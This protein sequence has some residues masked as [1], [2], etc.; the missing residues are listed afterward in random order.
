MAD[1]EAKTRPPRVVIFGAGITGLTVAHELIERG[2]DVQVVESKA[3]EESEYEVEVGGVAANQFAT[4]KADLEE[5]HPH[6]FKT[7]RGAYIDE[8]RRGVV[9]DQDVERGIPEAEKPGERE[10]LEALRAYPMQRSQ[11][12]ARLSQVFTFD[13]CSDGVA[14]FEDPEQE[15]T[16][17]RAGAGDQEF[18]AMRNS[19]LAL[20]DAHGITNEEKLTALAKRI[21]IAIVLR[22]ER[23]ATDIEAAER[24]GS[25]QIAGKLHDISVRREILVAEFWG[26]V[27]PDLVGEST[28]ELGLLRSRFVIWLLTEQA[29]AAQ[30][31]AEVGADG[32][33]LD[34]FLRQKSVYES[35]TDGAPEHGNRER[36][37]KA[38]A[39]IYRGAD[40]APEVDEFIRNATHQ[41]IA[42][43]AGAARPLGT[44]LQERWRSN[45]V[46]VRVVE[47]RLPGEHGYR[48][49]P[50]Y[51]RHLFN[52]MR[53]TP[54]LDATG[55]EGLETAFDQLVQPPPVAIAL[56][57]SGKSHR[58]PRRHKGIEDLRK[59]LA[60]LLDDLK[61]TQTDLQRFSFRLLVFLTSCRERRID[62][63]EQSWLE[64]LDG[65]KGHSA[66]YAMRNFSDQGQ[67][68]VRG[69]LR[70]LLAMDGEEI[71]AH[72]YALN[73]AQL[74]LD[75]R[76]EHAGADM[77]LIGPSSTTW[78][79]P[80]KR[81]LVTQ[82]VEF[83]SGELVGL[84][85][86]GDGLQPVVLWGDHPKLTPGVPIDRPIER[87][88][89]RDKLLGLGANDADGNL[90]IAAEYAPKPE[91]PDHEY[92][93]WLPHGGED[94]EQPDY[95][96]LALPFERAA[97][98][99]WRAHRTYTLD[100]DWKRLAEF[101]E[102]TIERDD[103]GFDKVQHS[104]EDPIHG[105]RRDESGR[106][107]GVEYPLR[108]LSGIQFFF[109]NN[110]RLVDGHVIYPHSAWGLSAISQMGHWRDRRSRRE[111]FLG[112]F[113]VDI[114]DFYRVHRARTNLGYL[115][116]VDARIRSGLGDPRTA[117]RS[118]W[119]E[120]AAR[121]W[122][123][124][125]QT[126]EPEHAKVLVPPR[127][128]HLDQGIYFESP[129]A[130]ASDGGGTTNDTNRMPAGNDTPFLINLPGQF[131]RRP[132]QIRGAAQNRHGA[133]R[134]MTVRPQVSNERWV[135]AGTYMAT[136]TR[137]MTMEAS[138][139]SGRH[140]VN[141][142]LHDIMK[143]E[144]RLLGSLCEIF[145]P[146]E[147]EVEDFAPLKELDKAL[148][149]EG[150]PHL[151]EILGFERL[152]QL[153]HRREGTVGGLDA[154]RQ[155]VERDWGFAGRELMRFLTPPSVRD[156]VD[157]LHGVLPDDA[158]LQ[159]LLAAARGS[160]VEASL[161]SLIDLF[162]YLD[163]WGVRRP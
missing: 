97:Q 106:P 65:A 96:L 127:Y 100:G 163:R 35:G 116:K 15:L 52:T 160:P 136:Y 102:L 28:R 112:Q 86:D 125:L 133:A 82:G 157:P 40:R 57:E 153:A 139:E 39:R 113:S 132:G 138:N 135:L 68:L 123:Q 24:Y 151:L 46:E 134:P 92:F 70:S 162:A 88:Q 154:L 95:Y 140:A 156:L 11:P 146:Y 141:T 58:I 31:A 120:L 67:Q 130:G 77:T 75:V 149:D 33:S 159:R 114:G 87:R 4:V 150:L 60:F 17:L 23:L 147:F 109:A 19:F 99:A 110:T 158:V 20:K 129:S 74:L 56:E 124:L 43:S 108:D 71:D 152:L 104:L 80:W 53:R 94:R 122:D 90:E 10:R 63:E 36:L 69:T 48:Y 79:R 18:D 59:T 9:R 29:A 142:I 128:Y 14:P 7:K 3:C 84:W 78:L 143:R 54:I 47:V 49:F 66:D 118:P 13:Y 12:S 119:S 51:Y 144:K 62:Y 76:D 25:I 85:D 73:S 101:D 21:A 34:V 50:A 27:D 105:T 44:T 117:W 26:H 55:D 148:H 42:R 137:L 126:I 38:L 161:Q 131:A 5:L 8:A 32:S 16:A 111:G 121:V 1:Q 61:L 72:S 41:L 103:L 89:E 107:V 98:L 93:G 45:R 30:D 91:N 81:Y 2:F 83:F 155:R 22:A 64:F 6:L 115:A 37:A 145:D